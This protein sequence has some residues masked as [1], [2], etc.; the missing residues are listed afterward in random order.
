[1]K[2]SVY[3]PLNSENELW[4]GKTNEANGSAFIYIY[5]IDIFIT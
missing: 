2:I 4:K 5:L 3:E 1:M